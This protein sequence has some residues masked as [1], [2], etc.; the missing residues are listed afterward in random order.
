[1]AKFLDVNGLKKLINLIKRDYMSKLE[2]VSISEKV[3]ILE[4]KVQTLEGK[5]EGVTEEKVNELTNAIVDPVKADVTDIKT[6]KIPDIEGRLGVLESS[7]GGSGNGTTLEQVNQA[8]DTKLN[9]VSAKVSTLESKV[10]TLENAPTAITLDQVNGA[11]DTK[12]NPV[13]TDVTTLKDTTVPAIE[14]TVQTLQEKVQDLENASGSSSTSVTET[15]VREIATEIVTPVSTIAN[16]NKNRII[17][18]QQSINGMGGTIAGNDSI[19]R[20][21]GILFTKS[22][23]YYLPISGKWE[24]QL[25]G[26]GGSGAP[27]FY[28]VEGNTRKIIAGGVGGNSG[29]LKTF[30]NITIRN[31]VELTIM[32]ADGTIPGGIGGSFSGSNASFTSLKI[33]G[34]STDYRALGGTTSQS[35]VGL[36]SESM[37][38]YNYNSLVSNIVDFNI[39]MKTYNGREDRAIGGAGTVMVHSSS[40]GGTTW[41]TFVEQ[42]GSN[43]M[44]GVCPGGRMDNYCGG[45]AGGMIPDS[46]ID[47]ISGQIP[48]DFPG[49]SGRRGAGYGAGGAGMLVTVT[50]S[51]EGVYTFTPP[52]DLKPHSGVQGAILFK[53]LG[54]PQ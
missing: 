8:I 47:A 45:G 44:N 35:R 33:S 29:E 34:D 14:S 17:S 37:P 22:G 27:G 18:V 39:N 31:N 49:D 21:L 13:K 20:R 30:T 12:L 9:P 11:I 42:I 2:G 6:T 3:D 36:F 48:F 25:V 16:D 53:Y 43:G 32:I 1:M 26:A 52:T 54:E 4:S 46:Y 19:W 40:D 7:A 24:I 10:E 50:K 41:S 38:R 5:P 23:K 51:S 15:K 28:F